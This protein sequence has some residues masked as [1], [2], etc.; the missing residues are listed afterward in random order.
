MFLDMGVNPLQVPTHCIYIISCKNISYKTQLY[1]TF[2]S[3]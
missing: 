2:P 3:T 1:C